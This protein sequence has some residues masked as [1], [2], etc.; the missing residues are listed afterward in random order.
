MWCDVAVKIMKMAH[1][2][3]RISRSRKN[4]N[5]SDSIDTIDEN[6]DLNASGRF[7]T[8]ILIF[9]HNTVCFQATCNVLLISY[10]VILRNNFQT[11]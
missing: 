7:L 4:L 9:L 10:S 5:R 2:F 8:E 3:R 6:E 11:T 1:L